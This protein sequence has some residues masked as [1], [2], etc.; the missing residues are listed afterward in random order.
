MPT[1]TDR[2]NALF[3]RCKLRIIDELR[4]GDESPF[5]SFVERLSYR[6]MYVI[7]VLYMGRLMFDVLKW[8]LR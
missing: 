5:N 2:S 3:N 6:I 7:A 8:W 4:N 1:N